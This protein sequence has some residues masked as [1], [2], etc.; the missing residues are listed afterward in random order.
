MIFVNLLQKLYN[1]FKDQ[2]PFYPIF[3]VNFLN[4]GIKAMEVDYVT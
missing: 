1:Y 2:D 4:R 3:C